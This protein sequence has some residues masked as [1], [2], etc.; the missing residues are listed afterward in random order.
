MI[1]FRTDKG[2]RRFAPPETPEQLQYMAETF[3]GIRLPDKA[4]CPNH[5]SPLQA[6]SDAFFHRA[7]MAVWKA[8]RGF[9]GKSTALAVLIE[10]E[11]LSGMDVS[12][13]GGSA[14]QSQS[15]HELM[16]QA[17]NR[18]IEVAPGVTVEGPFRQMLD[19]EPTQ[20]WTRGVLGN[21]VA[22]MTASTRSVRGPHPQR[23]RIDEVDEVPVAIMDAALGMPMASSPDHPERPEHI[24]SQVVLSST[25][26]YADGTM[27][28]VLS[29]ARDKGWPIYEWCFR[30]SLQENGG[31][32]S[33]AMVDEARDFRFPAYMWKTEVELQEPEPEGR[34]FDVET[35][36]IVFPDEKWPKTQRDL[37]NKRYVI[38]RPLAGA[39]YATGTDWGKDVDY[40]VISTLRTDVWPHRLVCWERMRRRSYRYMCDRANE[41]VSAYPGPHAHD[42]KGVGTVAEDL[43]DHDAIGFRADGIKRDILLSDY[44]LGCETGRIELPRLERLEI[45]HKYLTQDHLNGRKHCP[46]SIFSL[47]LAEAAASGKAAQLESPAGPKPGRLLPVM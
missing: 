22:C 36:K 37:E 47:A 34:V 46:D 17:W 26:Q 3:L 9:G 8:S 30:E 15:V 6:V 40:T 21:R 7:P 16:K 14:Q 45:D 41:R 32:L 2:D 5:V 10:L 28:E 29:R 31:W 39:T 44:V 13:L 23:L 42:R 43:L 38:E 4:V 18:T 27:S 19:Q 11:F 33:Q 12:I 20:W 35:M 1:V 25:H 24:A